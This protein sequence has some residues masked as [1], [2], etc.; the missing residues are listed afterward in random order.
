[1]I[2]YDFSNKTVLV[3]GASQGIGHA[4]ALAFVD[5]GATVH[6]TG[7]QAQPS[8][9]EADLSR[10]IYHK[11]ALQDRADREALA[12]SIPEL[13][14]LVNNAGQARDDEYEYEGF[15]QTM[16]V[17]LNAVVDLCYAFHARLA[18]RQGAIVN[19]GSSAS[20][21]ALRQVPAYTASK[22]GLLGFTRAL[23]DQWAPEGI[24]VNLV[25]PGFIDT[26]IID[27][28]KNRADGGAAMLRRIPQRRWG[29][30]S[31]VAV[32]VLFLAS[33]EASYITGQSLVVDGGLMLR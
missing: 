20:F 15:V 11:A 7:T 31:E 28:A 30:P 25:A 1:M 21:I 16:E 29:K 12:Q 33:A 4:I 18:Q 2:R 8:M 32:A 22:T 17:N 27:W 24:R 9:Y 13:D 23:A 14:V 5:A 3:T 6:V 19:L 10:F 26:K